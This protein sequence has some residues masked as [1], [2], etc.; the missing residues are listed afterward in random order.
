[1]KT[2][3]A[4]PGIIKARRLRAG[5]QSRPA[6]G[7]AWRQDFTGKPND[8][9]WI[10]VNLAYVRAL[11]TYFRAK[12]RFLMIND[13]GNS[14]PAYLSPVDQIALAKA[15]DGSLSEGFPIDGCAADTG[16]VDCKPHDGQFDAEYREFT[17]ESD[18]PYFAI[19]YL[20]NRSLERITRDQAAWATAAFLLG[21]RKPAINYLAVVGAGK[22]SPTIKPSSLTLQ[23]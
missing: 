3:Q 16:W 10:G 21:I 1:M 6:C 12:G 5:P 23:A 14:K 22:D 4:S 19:A 20:C 9:S 11:R 15:A 18:K 2:A 17:A 8:R 7:G 13:S